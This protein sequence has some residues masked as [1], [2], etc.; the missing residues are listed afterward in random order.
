MGDARRKRQSQTAL[1]AANPHCIYCGGEKPATTVDHMPPRILF[2]GKLRP[3]QFEFPSCWSCNQAT[4][5]SDLVCAWLAR[6]FPDSSDPRD[7]ADSKKMLAGLK[8]NAPEV[9]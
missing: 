8:N 9:L 3:A 4:K 1:L 6:I 2:R 5:T 7:R